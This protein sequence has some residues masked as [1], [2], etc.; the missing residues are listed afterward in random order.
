MVMDD[1]DNDIDD[2]HDTD[3]DD[4]HGNDDEDVHDDNNVETMLM[5]SHR[6]PKF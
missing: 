3:D 4:D 1:H 2:D 6:V 5:T